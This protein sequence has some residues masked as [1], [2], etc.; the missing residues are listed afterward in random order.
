MGG[1]Q[2]FEQLNLVNGCTSIRKWRGMSFAAF[3]HHGFGL[4]D[5]HLETSCSTEL[6][7]MLSWCCNPLGE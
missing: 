5:I 6:L 7:W 2:I 3:K 4:L 1:A